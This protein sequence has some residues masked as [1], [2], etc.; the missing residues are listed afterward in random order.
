MRF[1]NGECQMR[2]ILIVAA[3][4]AFSAGLS[5]AQGGTMQGTGTNHSGGVQKPI[6]NQNT[7]RTKT[8]ST[9]PKS[10]RDCAPGQQSGSAQNAAPGQQKGDANAAAPGQMKRTRHC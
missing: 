8:S 2:R 4:L 3:A 7:D 5:I 10:A 9:N 6:T 1:N